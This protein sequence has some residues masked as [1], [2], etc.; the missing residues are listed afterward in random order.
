MIEGF[1]CLRKQF[2]QPF[3]IGE[4]QVA[5]VL[6]NLFNRAAVDVDLADLPLSTEDVAA[7]HRQGFVSGERRRNGAIYYKLRFRRGGKQ[8]VIGIG[9]DKEAAD[10]IREEL[11][12]LQRQRDFERDL[13]ELVLGA[14]QL[15][16]SSRRLLRPLLQE[17]GYAFHG[18]E[19]R[20]S[21]DEDA[22]S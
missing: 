22:E 12:Q 4:D 16:R 8:V 1:I 7:L 13:N 5:A 15:L 2:W 10:N 19:I 3:F 18:Y 20:K 11:R 17:A 6:D 14:K 9:A 21:L